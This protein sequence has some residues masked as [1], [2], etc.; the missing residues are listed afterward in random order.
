MISYP[1][2][3]IERLVIEEMAA[4]AHLLGS[5]VAEIEIQPLGD[6]PNA[7]E[8]LAFEDDVLYCRGVAVRRLNVPSGIPVTVEQ[9][10][11]DLRV[12]GLDADVSLEDV[13]GTLRLMDLKGRT[14]LGHVSADIRAA[15]IADLQIAQACEGDLRIDTGES[16]S[17]ELVT[18]DVRLRDVGSVR[19]GRVRGDLWM[20][21]VRGALQVKRVDG[22][23]RL[24][25]LEGPVALQEILGDLRAAGLPGGLSAAR[26]SGDVILNGPFTAEDGYELSADGDTSI[27]LPAEADVR[28]VLRAGGRIRSD[29][30][31]TPTAD[32]SPTYTAVLGRG[33]TRVNLTT[34]GDMRVAQAGARPGA[35]AQ[36]RA[37]FDDIADLRN[38]GERIRQQVQASLAAA[39]I[40][41]RDGEVPARRERPRPPV[42]DRARSAT[43]EGVSAEEQMAILRM[44]E[45]GA[46]SP[47]EADILL[48]AL[49]A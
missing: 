26:V 14:R 46:I 1:A 6:E 39:G 20:E 15:K 28:L 8:A 24:N 45:T 27:S 10:R 35:G 23:V 32:G 47:E 48:K 18:G 2:E 37:Q 36:P 44:V 17:G 11:G 16:L 21:Q 5:D 12:S 40:A 42:G 33:S 41:P 3:G 19:L 43:A 7:R 22:D 49:E 34:G 29:V 38:L 31:L 25:D 9:A 30:T 13:Q 4:D